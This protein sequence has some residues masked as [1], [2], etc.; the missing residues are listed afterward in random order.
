MSRFD[1]QP[2]GDIHGECEAEIQSLK[3]QLTNYRIAHEQQAATITDLRAQL[4]DKDA[5]QGTFESY[6]QIVAEHSANITRLEAE[7]AKLRALLLRYR[8]ETPLGHQPHMITIE[9]DALLTPNVEI[10]GGRRPSGGA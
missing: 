8:N 2:D 4:A 10:T 5:V 9:V 1:E 6:A 7:N 3:Y